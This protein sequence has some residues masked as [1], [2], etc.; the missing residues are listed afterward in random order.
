MG[1]LASAEFLRTIYEQSLGGREQESPRVVLYSDPTFPDRT[2]ALLAGEYD[3][4]LARL[5]EALERLLALGVSRV[6]ICCITI[7][8][9]LPLLPADLRARVVSLI[10]VV[11]DEVERT[12]RRHLLVCTT[13]TRRLGLFERH[14]R[15]GRLK[16]FFVLAEGA[17]QA[18]IHE[19]IYRVKRNEDLRELTPRLE[20][21][22]AKYG[23]D[24]FIVGC[25]ETHLLAKQ[26]ARG[27]RA[28]GCID[29][30]AV[31]A[32]GVAESELVGE[33]I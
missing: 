26:V 1:P 12:R 14:E 15:W 24:S 6:V 4:L 21:L 17:D 25:T 9:L 23:V 27:P 2:D 18:A 5:V 30:L 10:D 3:E 13:G 19:L 32:R 28:Y 31:I 33:N 29:P 16:E 22:L 7:H 8:H 11:F 20:E